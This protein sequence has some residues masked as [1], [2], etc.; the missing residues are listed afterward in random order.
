VC[1]VDALV[2]A[3]VLGGGCVCHQPKIVGGKWFRKKAVF[4]LFVR[5]CTFVV[6]SVG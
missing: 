1:F 2:Y 6:V 4:G 3:K 5:A